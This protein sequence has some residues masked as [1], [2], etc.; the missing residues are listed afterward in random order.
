VLLTNLPRVPLAEAIG[1]STLLMIC[2]SGRF[3]PAMAMMTA[4]VEARYRGGFMSMNSSVQQL[5]CGLAAFLSGHL[6]GQTPGG[7]ITRFPVIGAISVACALL[8]IYLARY[9]RPGDRSEGTVAA[10][11]AEG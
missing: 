4:S 5:A 7:Q 11:P 10:L 6:L 8:C 2:M 9:V 1:V 3:V